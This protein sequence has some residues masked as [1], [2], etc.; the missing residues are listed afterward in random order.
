MREGRRGG[1]EEGREGDR[2]PK[3][4]RE[5]ALIRKDKDLSTSP[6]RT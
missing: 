6:M 5:R 4:E 3:R 1:R 2:P